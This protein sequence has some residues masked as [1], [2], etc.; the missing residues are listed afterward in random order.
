ML[1]TAALCSDNGD[2]GVGGVG[3]SREPGRGVDHAVHI[4]LTEVT[5][6]IHHVYGLTSSFSHPPCL[7]LEQWCVILGRLLDLETLGF[8]SCCVVW[9]GQFIYGRELF[10]LQI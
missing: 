1:I 10:Q 9:C 5:V 8:A 4:S 6:R 7:K 3:M 2:D